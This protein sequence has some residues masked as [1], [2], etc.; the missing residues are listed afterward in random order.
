MN[1]FFRT[2]GKWVLAVLGVVLMIMWVMPTGSSSGRNTDRVVGRANGKK[3]LQ[4]DLRDASDTVTTLQKFGVAAIREFGAQNEVVEALLIM[5][6]GGPD[7]NFKGELNERSPA[8]HFMLLSREARSLGMVGTDD[9]AFRLIRDAGMNDATFQDFCGR[10][11]L[12]PRYVRQALAE[13]AGI[14]KARDLAQQAVSASLP[15]V[16]HVAMNEQ[17]TVAA[18]YVALSAENPPESVHAPLS[19]AIAKQFEAYKDVPAD[20]ARRSPKEI[21]GHRFP[22]GYK[23]PDRVKVEYL[24]FSWEAVRAQVVAKTDEEKAADQEAAMAY[25]M[26][27]LKEFTE[28]PATAPA[29]SSAPSTMPAKVKSFAEVR[30]KLVDAQVNRRAYGKMREIAERAI[31]IAAEPFKLAGGTADKRPE[32]KPEAWVGYAAVAAKIGTAYG[33][34]PERSSAGPW[35]SAEGLEMLPGIGKSGMPTPSGQMEPF[36]GL[37]LSVR[38]ITPTQSGV[39]LRLQLARGAEGPVVFDEGLNA[40]VYRVVDAEK[41][42]APASVDEVREQVVQDLRRVAYFNERIEQAKGLVGEGEKNGIHA[43]AAKI[44]GK[45]VVTVP[46]QRKVPKDEEGPLTRNMR[47]PALPGLGVVPPFTEAAFALAQKVGPVEH[48]TSQP[49]VSAATSAP[50]TATAASQPGKGLPTAWVAFEPNLAAYV[51]ELD[52]YRPLA[53]DDFESRRVW[54][55]RRVTAV[56]QINL[57]REW[58]S[59]KAVAARLKYVN[60]NGS[61]IGKEDRE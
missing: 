57:A 26:D 55:G 8:L 29:T 19:D 5:V 31:A 41:S 18:A 60:E 17:S 44:G 25:Y 58:G 47:A 27:H 24:K 36:V 10:A 28:T 7:M 4:S 33:I 46:F 34:T 40:Y 42:H 54:V 12:S 43:V 53:S 59:L 45:V 50:A 16:E 9:D 56:D 1:E 20:E 13:Y 23:F 52:A 14:A 32:I 35:L 61:E 39:A 15:E 49:S 3:V 22:F 48:A 11:S 30:A 6:G 2:Y 21:G 37:A 38:E 51:L